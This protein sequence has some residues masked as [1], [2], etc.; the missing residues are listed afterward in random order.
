MVILVSGLFMPPKQLNY[1]PALFIKEY[2]KQIF[3][4]QEDIVND[5]ETV[6]TSWENSSVI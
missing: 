1:Q 4:P 2:A 3:P 6:K 5:E